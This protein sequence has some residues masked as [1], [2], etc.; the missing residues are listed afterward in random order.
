MTSLASS[1]SLFSPDNDLS[2]YFAQIR[3][4]PILT[5]EKESFY[6]RKL[7]EELDRRAAEPLINSH[8][9]LVVKIAMRYKN[10]GLP[11]I[12]LIAEGNIGLIKAVDNFDPEKG[13]RLSTYA[14]WWIKAAIQEYILHSWSL[15]KIGTTSA[16]KKLFFNLRK[17]KNKIAQAEQN[18]KMTDEAVET[19]ADTLNVSKK[20]VISMN[21]R[22]SGAD[23]S[24]NAQL[25]AES[26]DEWID[27]LEDKSD[28]QEEDFARREEMA[29]RKDLIKRA[30]HVLNDR[31]KDILRSRHFREKPLTLEVLSQ[32]YN[33]SR[34][35]IRQIETNA[36]K[37]I[38]TQVART[39]AAENMVL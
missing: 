31:E 38:K 18:Y 33:V 2:A 19:I 21:Q 34:E 22:M 1:A 5:Q 8:L 32:M 36:L 25:N 10:Y 30:L 12:D 23:F 29:L 35:R 3:K 15:V 39:V 7:V 17:M 27:W 16:Q 11:M 20:D 4:Y 6:A 26:A 37:K 24:L 13:F 9:R 14:M 28:N